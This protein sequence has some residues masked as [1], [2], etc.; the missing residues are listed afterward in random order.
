MPFRGLD[1]IRGRGFAA[2]VALLLLGRLEAGAVP[3]AKEECDKLKAEQEQ[4]TQAGVRVTMANGPDWAKAN[5]KADKLA[6]IARLIDVDAQVAFR[7][8]EPKLQPAPALKAEADKPRPKVRKKA[9]AASEG[10]QQGAAQPTKPAQPQAARPA[11]SAA[12]A[13]P[14]PPGTGEVSAQPK[15]A[16]RRAQPKSKAND[17][18]VPPAAA[19]AQP[20]TVPNAAPQ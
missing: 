11:A 5:L 7:C 4:L 3:L 2:V 17:A 15:P 13:T 18:Y 9:A 10:Q 1:P 14:A 6:Q 19:A 12:S 20:T 16:P 8:I